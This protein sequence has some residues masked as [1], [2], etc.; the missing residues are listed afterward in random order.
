MLK[1]MC[2]RSGGGGPAGGPALEEQGQVIGYSNPS[3][4]L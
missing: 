3:G 2:D 4:H 1:K